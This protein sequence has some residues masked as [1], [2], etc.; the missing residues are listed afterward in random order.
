VLVFWGMQGDS[1]GVVNVFTDFLDA[2]ELK[3]EV[4]EVLKQC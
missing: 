3:L 2:I 4:I 1:S